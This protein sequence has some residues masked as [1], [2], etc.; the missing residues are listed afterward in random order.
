MGIHAPSTGT[1]IR[2][3]S[4]I[5]HRPTRAEHRRRAEAR[6]LASLTAA[7]PAAA[8]A[9]AEIHRWVGLLLTP[10]AVSAAFFG[11]AL[12][13]GTEWPMV[14]AVL[15]GPTLMIVAYIYLMLTCDTNDAGAPEAR[16]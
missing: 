2:T 8:I 6:R 10:L 12:G 1:R 3:G 14:P 16:H 15:L 4:A 9:T 11:L 13:T 7:D 5:P